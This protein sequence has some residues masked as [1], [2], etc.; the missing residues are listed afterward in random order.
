MM[1]RLGNFIRTVSFSLKDVG[2][3]IFY[4]SY[5]MMN[6]HLRFFKKNKIIFR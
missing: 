1:Q 2:I 6:A 4:A 3:L 5:D